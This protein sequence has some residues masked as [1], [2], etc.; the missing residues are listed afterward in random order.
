MRVEIGNVL[1]REIEDVFGRKILSSRDCIQLSEEI[2]EKT[3][4]QLN[5][6]TLRRFFGLVK[7]AYPPSQYTLLI[8][9]KYC[10]FQSM[11]EVSKQKTEAPEEQSNIDKEGFLKYLISIISDNTITSYCD[12]TFL[13]VLKQTIVFLNNYPQL[14]LEFQR[15]IAKSKNGQDYY[16]ETFVNVDH[17]NRF[18][19]RGLLYYQM[20]KKTMES[21][22][23]VSSV[24]AYKY[25]L[26]GNKERL[27]F[28]D[29]QLSHLAVS[30]IK[31]PHVA[32]RFFAAQLFCA[33]ALKQQTEDL[34]IEI[35]KYY[36]ILTDAAHP[37]RYYFEYTISESLVL[38]GHFNDALYYLEQ[39]SKHIDSG[40]TC[41][42][43]I[44][45]H[46]HRLLKAIA[47]HKTNDAKAEAI[48]NFIKPS[49]F[50]FLNKN[51]F[52][53]LYLSLSNIHHKKSNK[54][55]QMLAELFESTGFHRLK[56][57]L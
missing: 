16:Y 39:L 21:K 48:F 54:N 32:C 10:G 33:E 45:D 23:F 15:T 17:L 31:N 49:K 22:P 42:V 20:E 28:Y 41:A 34:L 51:L 55:D 35:Y 57:F 11:E 2:F 24:F 14:A 56:Y 3:H 19:T 47:L 43:M 7:A 12:K 53:I 46:N 30:E 44:S 29:K 26:N 52:R 27:D 36:S 50:H 1:R 25:W 9:S 37:A 13:A 8:L 6:N 4:C 38:T 40:K 18:F 5:S